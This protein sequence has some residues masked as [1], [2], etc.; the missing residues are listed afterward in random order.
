MAAALVPGR[1]GT[2]GWADAFSEK[3]GVTETGLLVVAGPVVNVAGS[4]VFVGDGTPVDPG[5]AGKSVGGCVVPTRKA[6]GIVDCIV[7]T[8]PDGFSGTS[9]AFEVENEMSVA[10]NAA[11]GVGTRAKSEAVSTK[12]QARK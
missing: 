4:S 11:T 10:P 3:V 1:L 2:P 7:A 8:G 9:V 12:A 5:A 6:G